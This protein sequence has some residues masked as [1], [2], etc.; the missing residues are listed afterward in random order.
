MGYN[1]VSSHRPGRMGGG[2][3][4][5]HKD[6]I[7]VKKKDAGISKTSEHLTVEL[8]NNSIMAIIYRPPNTSV[9]NFLQEFAEW[10]SHLLNKY[11]D[12]L[13]LG[14]LNVNLKQPDLPNSAA[15]L[16]CLD[17]YALKQWV[18]DPTHQSG[19][20][21][22]HIIARENSTLLLD[23]PKV[24]ELMSDHRVIHF[25]I[26]R[27]KL[28]CKPTMVKFRKLNDI[29]SQVIKQEIADILDLCDGIKDPD[30][31]L[32][33]TNEAWLTAL[34]KIAPEKETKKRDRKRLPWFNADI[35]AYK[36]Q[37]RRMETKFI[38]SGSVVHKR[39]Y[40]DARNF[41]LQE[42]KNAKCRYLNM[43]VEETHGDQKKLFG[44]LN[45][46]TIEPMRNQLPPGSE[47]SLAEGF[48][49]F[50]QEKIEVIRKSF[51]FKNCL[52]VAVTY[53][54]HLPRMSSFN[55]VL[56]DEIRKLIGKAKPTTCVLDTI[57]TKLIKA[58]Q[59]VFLPLVTMLINL[60]LSTGV[61]PN[62]W[63]RTI[64]RPLL[65]KSGLETVLKNYRPV[66]NLNFISKLL[67]AA[68]LTQLQDHLYSQK[69]L[70]QYQSSCRANF[71]TETLLV[72]LLDD[73]LN[74]MELQEV[75]AL[76]ALDLSAA[77]DTVNHNLLLV[78]L[79]SHF[80]VDGTPLAWIKSYLDH[81]SFQVQVGTALSQSIEL[82]YAVPQGSLIGPVL[83]ICY[84]STLNDIIQDTSA[85]M[86]GYADDHVVY[87]SF[88]PTI[89][90]S[91]LRELMELTTSIRDWMRSSFLKMND[92]KSELVI[93]GTQNQ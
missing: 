59:D 75:T 58:H 24:L 11:M 39:E 18:L 52:K 14:D 84:I 34:N 70:P 29:S 9:S 26:S 23:S 83:F 31:Y 13:I 38:K 10:V 71:S 22:D 57:P 37:K 61:F 48:T 81:R 80:G 30:I 15:F 53:P 62:T 32:E 64:V 88:S 27:H 19:S 66:S 43:A 2:L 33:C 35:L 20:L 68:V 60:S 87:K 92:S 28:P 51:D 89:E 40:Q 45:S 69:L 77:F 86:L 42:L 93:F 44:L 65:R 16:E 54:N 12:P 5:I 47:E 4:L 8:A 21:L 79:K 36:R 67:E 55:A 50:F 7:E 63:K 3:G 6:N 1:L 82:P 74:G 25:D 46:L 91:A 72:K 90:V 56:Q 49:F 85:S 17:S 78:I 76:V 41:Y 73:I